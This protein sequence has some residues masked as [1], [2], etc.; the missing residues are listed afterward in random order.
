MNHTPIQASVSVPA[1]SNPKRVILIGF[2]LVQLDQVKQ[3]LCSP[4]MLKCE[5]SDEEALQRL[6]LSSLWFKGWH[7]PGRIKWGCWRSVYGFRLALSS[8]RCNYCKRNSALFY[9]LDMNHFRCLVY[10]PRRKNVAQ[11]FVFGFCV[12]WWQSVRRADASLSTQHKMS[13]HNREAPGHYIDHTSVC[14]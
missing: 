5:S 6:W 10:H 11:I 7:F 13:K 3:I 9:S 8:D 14:C 1:P 12:F 4:F 2:F